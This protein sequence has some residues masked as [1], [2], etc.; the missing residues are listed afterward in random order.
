MDMSEEIKENAVY[1]TSEAMNLLR[2]SESTMKRL[3]KSGLI[4]ANKIGK[5][6]R[7]LGAELLR[8]LSPSLERQVE[9]SYL[10]IKK[11]VV[12]KVNKW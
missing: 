10:N 1:T 11:K 12:D 4:K 6:Y 8:A 2:V 5:Q 3:L 9:R 7:I